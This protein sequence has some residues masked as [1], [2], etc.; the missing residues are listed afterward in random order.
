MAKKQH[1][2][3]SLKEQVQFTLQNLNGIF[4]SENGN[5]KMTLTGLL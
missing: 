2:L 5:Y 3:G 4:G 1:K